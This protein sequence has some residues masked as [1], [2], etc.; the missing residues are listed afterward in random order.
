VQQHPG[1]LSDGHPSGDGRTDFPPLEDPREGAKRLA[2]RPKGL[3]KGAGADACGGSVLARRPEA[4]VGPPAPPE[5]GRS[6]NDGL[7]A[8]AQPSSFS[9]VSSPIGTLVFFD[10]TE[11]L[12]RPL[13]QHLVLSPHVPV[14]GG[15]DAVPLVD[16]QSV[17]RPPRQSVDENSS[18]DEDRLLLLPERSQPE[19]VLT[20][21]QLS[22]ASSGQVNQQAG[23][24]FC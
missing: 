4:S 12:G 20:P 21:L 13:K 23:Q 24:N 19:V 5:A 22:G 11:N 16:V 3:H 2:S 6:A 1:G 15:D 8:S 17:R 18:A 14:D 10:A 7:S 9:Q